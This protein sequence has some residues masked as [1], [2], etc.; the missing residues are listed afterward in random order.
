VSEGDVMNEKHDAIKLATT[1]LENPSID[2]D[3][4][5]AV[6]ARQFLRLAERFD[7]QVNTQQK[8][9]GDV[10]SE[11]PNL[12]SDIE[13]AL[14]D[15]HFA[16]RIKALEERIALQASANMKLREEF[17][18]C[19]ERYDDRIKALECIEKRRPMYETTLNAR[20]RALE[21]ALAKQRAVNE[22]QLNGLLKRHGTMDQMQGDDELIASLRD[23]LK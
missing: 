4:D 18:A 20:I 8:R 23:A 15:T 11:L 10:M 13:E 7:V 6:W 17:S 12:P 2:P 16:S 21:A 9:E 19:L 5:L 22:A 1:V 3:G 14:N